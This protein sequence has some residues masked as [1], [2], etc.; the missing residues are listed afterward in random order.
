MIIFPILND[1]PFGSQQGGGGS[2]QPVII[3]LP[4]AFPFPISQFC[5]FFLDQKMLTA[6]AGGEVA[7]TARR[8]LDEKRS[9][10]MHHLHPMK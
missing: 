5:F 10:T 3:P 6:T 7:E 8:L 9:I 1:E 2:N 4:R